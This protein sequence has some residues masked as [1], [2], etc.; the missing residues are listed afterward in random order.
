VAFG[1]PRS[2]DVV[3]RVF[4][5]TGREVTRQVWPNLNA[6]DH[7]L[8]WEARDGFGRPLRMGSYWLRL[9]TQAGT[10]TVRWIVLR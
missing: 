2:G 3:L 10:Q 4:D 1:L 7:L 6:G 5:A 8:P 9:Y